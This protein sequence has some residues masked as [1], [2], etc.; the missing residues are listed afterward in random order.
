MYRT[1]YAENFKK[2]MNQLPG[3]LGYANL[4]SVLQHVLIY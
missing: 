1:F 2:E 3:L 4:V